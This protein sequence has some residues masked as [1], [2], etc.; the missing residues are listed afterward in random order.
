[1]TEFIKINKNKIDN[2]F[3]LFWWGGR[4]VGRVSDK[5]Y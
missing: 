2:F 3:E 4:A 5:Y 1:M